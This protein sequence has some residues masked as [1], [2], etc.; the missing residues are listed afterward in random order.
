MSCL[1]GLVDLF[2]DTEVGGK[3]YPP[4]DLL[5]DN[6]VGRKVYPMLAHF[7]KVYYRNTPGWTSVNH[8]NEDGEPEYLVVLSVT[9]SKS[10]LK[11]YHPE[12]DDKVFEDFLSQSFQ[13][14]MHPRDMPSSEWHRILDETQYRFHKAKINKYVIM[15]EAYWKEVL[16]QI[17]DKFQL[18][19]YST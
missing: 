3:L 13:P 11:I 2:N 1:F 14:C 8:V 18:N 5:R 10:L 7:D 9:A 15:T 17:G 19:I 12:L 16:R 6:E 4:V